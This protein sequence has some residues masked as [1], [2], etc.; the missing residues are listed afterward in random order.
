MLSSKLQRA[1]Y[2]KHVGTIRSVLFETEDHDGYML[3]FTDNYIRVTMPFDQICVNTVIPIQL[4]KINGDGQ[5]QGT[6]VANDAAAIQF[7]DH[8][9]V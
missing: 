4:G 9:I 6:S 2:E 8:L 3:G 7:S 5:C 1:F